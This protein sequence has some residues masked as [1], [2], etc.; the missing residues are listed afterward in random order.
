MLRSV[1]GPVAWA[2]RH[3]RRCRG[4]M[5]LGHPLNSGVGWRKDGRKRPGDMPRRFRALPTSLETLSRWTQSSTRSPRRSSD[6]STRFEGNR[7]TTSLATTTPIGSTPEENVNAA[8]FIRFQLLMADPPNSDDSLVA[9]REERSWASLAHVSPIDFE[10]LH[11]TPEIGKIRY[12]FA[13]AQDRVADARDASVDRRGRL[14]FRLS[15][16][17]RRGG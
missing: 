1:A 6:C 9:D 8:E 4:S 7:T 17:V 3:T 5:A 12:T 11:T 2:D 14:P 16:W 15:P 10:T 13:D